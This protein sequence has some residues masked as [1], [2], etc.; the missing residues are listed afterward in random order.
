[1]NVQEKKKQEEEE[2]K[3]K[4]KEKTEKETRKM[5]EE[6]CDEIQRKT[7]AF[8][9][10]LMEQFDC[11]KCKEKAALR[12]KQHVQETLSKAFQSEA[13]GS[14]YKEAEAPTQAQPL[15]AP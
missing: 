3:K 5:F 9:R 13:Q 7:Q 1:V 10:Q 6:K 4:I 15:L 14:D 11:K 12:V 8:A 2:R